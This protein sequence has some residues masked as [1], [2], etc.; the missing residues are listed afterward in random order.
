[1][2]LVVPENRFAKIF[3]KGN[4]AVVLEDQNGLYYKHIPRKPVLVRP[5][6]YEL[7]NGERFETG[8]FAAKVPS[9]WKRVCK[10][11]FNRKTDKAVIFTGPKII[12]LNQDWWSTLTTPERDFVMAHEVAHL[13]TGSNEIDTDALAAKMM[14]RGLYN[15]TQIWD[16]IGT[17][18]GP[19]AKARIPAIRKRLIANQRKS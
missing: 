8:S 18:K 15:P 6:T 4:N 14:L 7:K 2:E 12:G 1:M 16:A 3:P 9:P 5:G 10:V 17:L 11:E 19:T 13:K